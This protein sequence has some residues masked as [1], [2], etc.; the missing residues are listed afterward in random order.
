MG[1]FEEF[2]QVEKAGWEAQGGTYHIG[3]EKLTSLALPRLLDLTDVGQG[4]KLAIVAC[5]PGFG[6][7]LAA[8]LGADALG[9]DFSDSMLETAR[10]R[11]PGHKFEQ[12]DAEN[13][14]YADNSFDGLICP[15]GVLHFAYPKQ[16]LAEF[17]RVLKPGGHMAYSLWTSIE[18]NPFFPMALGTIAK[19]GTLD[20]P[21]PTGPD[22]FD[23]ADPERAQ[24]DL[25]EIG[26]QDVAVTALPL[27]ARSEDVGFLVE[28]LKY[29]TVR[30]KI[31]LDAQTPEA[32]EAVFAD[33]LQQTEALKTPEGDYGLPFHVTCVGARKP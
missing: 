3:T 11:Y 1:T 28:A 29:S 25:G 8:D 4:D 30:T 20:V 24:A 26:F 21:M 17:F 23:Y 10:Q 2:K 19:H 18:T 31:T 6:M 7:D 33:L 16:A 9:V 5:G 27:E 13:L 14:T 12:G 32:R 15:F 22:M